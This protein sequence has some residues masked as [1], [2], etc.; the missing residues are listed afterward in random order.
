M[1]SAIRKLLL[2]L[3]IFLALALIG[4]GTYYFLV[5]RQPQSRDIVSRP[6]LSPAPPLQQSPQVAGLVKIAQGWGLDL[7]LI[8]PEENR[9]RY[10]DRSSGLFMAA[11]F[12]IE[13]SAPILQ[14]KFEGVLRAF[15]AKTKNQAILEYL[16]KTGLPA[17]TFLDL[18]SGTT[19]QFNFAPRSLYSMPI[20]SDIAWSPDDSQIA[21]HLIDDSNNTNIIGILSSDGTKN[22]TIISTKKRGLMLFWIAKDTLLLLE[23]PAPGVSNKLLALTI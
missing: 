21:Y 3:I 10:F 8:I 15:W 2:V 20:V 9:V 22:K 23:K 14:T 19:T 1:K 16:D 13:Q 7:S 17:W 4:F 6:Q 5:L 12:D 11:R 18:A